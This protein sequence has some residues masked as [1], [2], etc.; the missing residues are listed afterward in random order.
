MKNLFNLFLGFDLL[1]GVLNLKNNYI[2][3]TTFYK[4]LCQGFS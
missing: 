3:S 4:G 1:K 2:Q